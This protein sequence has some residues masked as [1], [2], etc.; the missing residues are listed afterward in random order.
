LC[1]HLYRV[2]MVASVHFVCVSTLSMFACVHFYVC[3][4]M[5]VV[6][7]CIYVC[8]CV[9]VYVALCMPAC[10]C[11]CPCVPVV[12]FI[13][14]S[15]LETILPNNISCRNILT[16]Q[17]YSLFTRCDTVVYFKAV[18]ECIDDAFEYIHDVL[19]DCMGYVFK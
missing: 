4:F 18:F 12:S 17:L 11:V 3:V 5:P 9:H 7:F 1:V 6:L 16:C 13:Y 2:Y 14:T 8:V 15:S 19:L 10:L